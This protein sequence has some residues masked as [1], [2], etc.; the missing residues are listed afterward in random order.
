MSRVP[1]SPVEAAPATG[2][3]SA[4]R[5]PLAR[6]RDGRVLGGVAAALGA[7][8]RLP[9]PA[10]RA[11]LVLS[12][13]AQGFGVVL[14]LW[15]WALTPIVESLD[16]VGGVSPGRGPRTAAPV[17]PAPAARAADGVP[18]GVPVGAVPRSPGGWR[19]ARSLWASRGLRGRLG[20]RLGDLAVGVL[21]L[22]LAAAV[23]ARWRGWD[24]RTGQVLPALVMAGGA[25]VAYTQLD[26]VERNRWASGPRFGGRAAA[27]RVIG[28]L[29]LLLLGMQFALLQRTDVVTAGRMMAS[30]GAVLLGAALVFAPWAVRLWRGLGAERAARV[31]EAERADIAAHLHDSVLQ[32]LAMIQRHSG[33]QAAVARLARAQERD[34]REWL[35]GV[36]PAEVST[37]A[38]QVRR[39]AA[40]AED[41]HGAAVE[42]V[43]VGD[44]ELAEPVS[45]LAA[46]LREAILNAAR[47]AGGTVQV[48]VECGPDRIEA[49]V[50]DRGPG[51]DLATVP[52]DRGG[53]RESIIG[54]MERHGGSAEVR[55]GPGEGTEVRLALPLPGQE[56]G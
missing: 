2:A 55:S 34:L 38:G 33:D 45:S 37:L 47:H 31:R 14:Y 24:I 11:A 17:G 51:F 21:L 42:V 16:A 39:V 6:P 52:G 22:M 9:V 30:G 10:V 4:G 49:F 36:P 27:L 32:T 40:D 29:G 20:V 43:L 25:L 12:C 35:Y 5:P 19:S 46:A 1:V 13:A 53:V 18:P 56:A 44:R 50:R 3:R 54:R 7:H 15:L 28:G 41:A 26:E 23:Y 48:Y 8:L